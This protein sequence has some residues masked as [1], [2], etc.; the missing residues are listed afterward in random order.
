MAHLQ[1]GLACSPAL[2]PYS[3]GQQRVYKCTSVHSKATPPVGNVNRNMY[4]FVLCVVS[5]A[6]TATGSSMLIGKGSADV[7]KA[8]TRAWNKALRGAWGLM[9]MSGPAVGVQSI[10]N[11]YVILI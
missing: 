11:A 7:V 1:V 10:A 6:L 5:I 3:T 4:I 9:N 8:T 2:N